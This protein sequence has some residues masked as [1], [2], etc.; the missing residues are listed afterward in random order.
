M[1]NDKTVLVVDDDEDLVR[2]LG[3]RLRQKGYK[4]GAAQ[5]ANQAVS[6]QQDTGVGQCLSSRS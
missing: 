5:D 3:I 4:V 2:S 6:C 1:T